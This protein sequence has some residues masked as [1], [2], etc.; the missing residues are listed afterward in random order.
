MMLNVT[1][2]I[3]EQLFGVEHYE[4]ATGGKCDAD[5][6]GKAEKQ[7]EKEKESPVY[8]CH[9]VFDLATWSSAELKRSMFSKIDL[10]ASE[11]HAFQPELPPEA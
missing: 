11:L 2:P 9:S 10:P 1:V 5:E 7:K 6:E 8:S 3:V 4:L